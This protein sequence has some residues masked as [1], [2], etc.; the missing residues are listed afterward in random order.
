MLA[1]TEQTRI[2]WQ[3]VRTIRRAE[4]VQGSAVVI[5]FAV[6]VPAPI[7]IGIGK[8]A[9]AVALPVARLTAVTKEFSVG[10][11]SGHHRG[12]IANDAE[13]L[14]IAEQSFLCGRQYE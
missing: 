9:F 8:L 4:H 5:S 6:T 7:G 3:I 2:D 12:A 1:G 11:I 13:V 14:S 10:T